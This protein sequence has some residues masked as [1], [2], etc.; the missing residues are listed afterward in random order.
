MEPV[1]GAAQGPP[2][3]VYQ[4][5]ATAGTWTSYGPAPP[6]ATTAAFSGVPQTWTSYGM[7]PTMG[8]M[9]ISAASSYVQV[10]PSGQYGSIPSQSLG[11]GS[12]M[13]SY[14]Q[15]MPSGQYVAQ[16]QASLPPQAIAMQMPQV[17]QAEGAYQSIGVVSQPPMASI[18]SVGVAAPVVQASSPMAMPVA[19]LSSPVQSQSPVAVPS[20]PASPYTSAV[21]TSAVY[22]NMTPA[23]QTIQ[24]VGPEQ[25]AP[26]VEVPQ[27]AEPPRN[28]AKG[29]ATGKKA[30][31]AKGCYCCN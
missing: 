8:G 2:T 29:A 21:Y 18:N 7:V 27:V 16:P 6:T 30:K 17:Q 23:V 25:V 20:A 31:K 24:A 19:Y 11:N 3:A 12:V 14:V 22:S 28:T 5:P 9:D 26:A 15:V 10:L 1:T 4:T 13:T